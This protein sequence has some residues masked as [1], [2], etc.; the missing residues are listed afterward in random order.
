MIEPRARRRRR[1]ARAVLSR[2]ALILVAGFATAC[3]TPGLASMPMHSDWQEWHRALAPG[4][5]PR[6]VIGALLVRVAR[7]LKASYPTW[8]VTPDTATQSVRI[9]FTIPEENGQRTYRAA[10][11]LLVTGLSTTPE[12]NKLLTVVPRSAAAVTRTRDG[13]EWTVDGADEDLMR[14]TSDIQNVLAKLDAR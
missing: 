8:I 1:T 14:I 2:F 9:F 11:N 6:A 5:E 7:E 10:V 12:G 4:E 3:G 13:L